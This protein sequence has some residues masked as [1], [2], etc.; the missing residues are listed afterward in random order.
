MKLFV[1][2]YTRPVEGNPPGQGLGIIC[3]DFDQATGNL[4][5]EH[6]TEA[7]NPSYLSITKNSKFLFAAQELSLAEEP[8]ISCYAIDPGNHQLILINQQEI[9]GGLA[10]HTEISPIEN[11][12]VVSCYGTGNV[13]VYPFDDQGLKPLMANIQH[14]GS[15][16]NKDR[17]EGP[18]AHMAGCDPRSDHVLVCDL[19][20]DKV[21]NYRL[22]KHFTLD[23]SQ[24]FS[25]VPAGSGPRHLTFHPN[26]RYVFVLNEMGATVSVFRYNDGS[27][28]YLDSYDALPDGYSGE[29]SAAAIRISPDGDF[30]Y[31]SNRGNDSI[32]IFKFSE[33]DET[34]ELIGNQNTGGKEPRD[35]NLDPSGNWLLS[36]NQISNDIAVFRRDSES[37][38]ITEVDRNSEASSP[39]CL[40]WLRE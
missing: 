36:A 34:L 39:V 5:L 17:Q 27:L 33:Q 37:G 9:P 16:V 26:N 19:G 32:S 15:G 24:P 40:Q 22:R 1:G 29:R 7:V 3:Y 18:H 8:K 11:F 2:S 28:T 20:I 31:T 21:L 10:C 38:L 30:V 12:V 13:V 6:I 4:T 14:E 35:F 23:S 25:R